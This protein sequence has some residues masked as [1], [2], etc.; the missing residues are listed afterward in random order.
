[1]KQQKEKQADVVFSIKQ[2]PFL[3]KQ[4][5]AVESVGALVHRRTLALFPSN[6]KHLV[7]SLL[8]SQARLVDPL[9]RNQVVD[10]RYDGTFHGDKDT[11]VFDETIQIRFYCVFLH[12]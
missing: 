7:P 5:H 9:V 4:L 1:M 8:Q 3:E 11:N 12:P 10:H 6:Q 2:R